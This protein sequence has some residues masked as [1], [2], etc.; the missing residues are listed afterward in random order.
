MSLDEIA[1]KIT[2]ASN[3]VNDFK[4]LEETKIVLSD[5]QK[6]AIKL[7][8]E[9]FEDI[10][11][12]DSIQ[13]AIFETAKANQIKPRDFFTVLYQ[14]LLNSNRGP[15]LGPYISTMGV[16]NVIESLKKNLS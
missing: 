14:M 5:E 10:T 1:E 4:S 8:I 2:Y 16:K 3:W 6:E 9:R 15:K 7:L 12:A 13:T 11:D